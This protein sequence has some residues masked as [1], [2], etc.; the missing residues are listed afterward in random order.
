MGVTDGGEERVRGSVGCKLV[1]PTERSRVSSAVRG[2]RDGYL[3]AASRCKP[4]LMCLVATVGLAG[5][6]GQRIGF[7]RARASCPR[8]PV[9]LIVQLEVGGNVEG[10]APSSLPMLVK[11]EETR[12]RVLVYAQTCR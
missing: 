1:D 12:A 5:A 7:R 8:Q 2:R 11:V 10:L 9:D 3:G 6:A 4:R